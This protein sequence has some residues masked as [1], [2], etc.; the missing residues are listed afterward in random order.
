[1]FLIAPTENVA[2]A[3]KSQYSKRLNPT[4]FDVA[5]TLRSQHMTLKPNWI[6]PY[7]HL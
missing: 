5:F 6:Q 2:A 4:D 7:W 3:K 1:M